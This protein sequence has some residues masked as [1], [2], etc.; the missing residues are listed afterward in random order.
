MDGDVKMHITCLTCGQPLGRKRK[1]RGRNALYCTIACRRKAEYGERRKT[2][3]FESVRTELAEAGEQLIRWQLAN[4]PDY[5]DELIDLAEYYLPPPENRTRFPA[6]P[7]V[8]DLLISPSRSFQV[9]SHDTPLPSSADIDAAEITGDWSVMLG[10]TLTSMC[11]QFE[12]GFKP[13]LRE[14][15]DCDVSYPVDIAA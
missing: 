11:W 9:V 3:Q 7:E 4:N 15:A 12:H 1:T 14:F 13:D 6:E 8:I 10:D 5:T 2:R